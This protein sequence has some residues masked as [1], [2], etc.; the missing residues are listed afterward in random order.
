MLNR[1]HYQFVKELN[2]DG[3]REM[4]TMWALEFA[5]AFSAAD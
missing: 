5:E 2:E 1:T 3:L 4:L